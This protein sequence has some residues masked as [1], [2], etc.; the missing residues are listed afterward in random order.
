MILCWRSR[1]TPNYN[2]V[3][4]YNIRL[5]DYNDYITIITEA[6]DI[7]LVIY[8]FYYSYLYLCIIYIIN[9]C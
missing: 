1:L 8:S 7:R 6:F 5:I 2:I 3:I 9:A 4:S